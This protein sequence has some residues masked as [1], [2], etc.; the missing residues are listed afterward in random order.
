MQ[1]FYF[2]LF[3]FGILWS[4]ISSLNVTDTRTKKQLSLI[5]VVQFPNLECTSTTS[6]ATSGT[7]I[8]TS[9]C[10]SKSGTAAGTCAAGFGVCCVVAVSTCGSTLSSN[11]SYIRNPG[12]PSSYTSASAG[13]CSYTIK[14]FSDD[15]CQLRLDFQEFSGFVVGGSGA[16]TD[17]FAAA[18][19]TGKNPPSICG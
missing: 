16:C 4:K 14:K 5:T 19:Q 13:T 11:T 6:S 17:T 18:G 8:T 9:E 1:I 3:I 2:S 10:S 7:C 15:I 12:Y